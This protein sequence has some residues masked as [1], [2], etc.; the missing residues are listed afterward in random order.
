MHPKVRIFLHER[1]RAYAR[2]DTGIIRSMNA[3]LRR[4]GVADTATL[5]NPTGKQQRR[6]SNPASGAVAVKPQRREK[7][8][9][10]EHENVA[11]RCEI[12]NPELAAH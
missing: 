6:S 7:L 12:C 3:E 8:Q 10:C 5:A 9:R 4:L 2:G 1:D 11:E